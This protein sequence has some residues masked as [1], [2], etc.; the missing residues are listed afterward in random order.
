[1][2]ARGTYPQVE[3]GAAGLIDARV[4]PVTSSTSVADALAAARRRD[5]HA[6]VALGVAGGAALFMVAST[7]LRAP[8]RAVLSAILPRRRRA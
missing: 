2:M 8:E 1:M 3:V 7:L 6:V 4:I 5:A